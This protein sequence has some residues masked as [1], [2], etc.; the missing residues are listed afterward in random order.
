M[1]REARA[2][3]KGLGPKGKEFKLKRGHNRTR[4]QAAISKSISKK[5][6]QVTKLALKLGKSPVSGSALSIARQVVKKAHKLGLKDMTTG[7]VLTTLGKQL[8]ESL[9]EGAVLRKLYNTRQ[10]AEVE[11][12]F[13]IYTRSEL[14]RPHFY[15]Y[16]QLLKNLKGGIQIC[17]KIVNPDYVDDLL[18]LTF[19]SVV[20]A[21]HAATHL[22]NMNYV[23]TFSVKL[24]LLKHDTGAVIGFAVGETRFSD[25]LKEPYAHLHIVCSA[26]GG[27]KYG[28]KLF[29]AA[30]KYYRDEKVHYG[31]HGRSDGKVR[32]LELDAL[33]GQGDYKQNIK[34]AVM[35]VKWANAMDPPIASRVGLLSNPA[36]RT[37]ISSKIRRGEGEELALSLKHV[38]LNQVSKD[39]YIDTGHYTAAPQTRDEM[40]D[41]GVGGGLRKWSFLPPGYPHGDP[42]SGW[43]SDSSRIKQHG[44][45]LT[46]ENSTDTT[47]RMQAQVCR[48][49]N[50]SD[51]DL[52]FEDDDK[53]I[54]QHVP[55][56]YTK[57][58]KNTKELEKAAEYIDNHGV[59]LIFCLNAPPTKQYGARRKAPVRAKAGATT[60]QKTRTA[61]TRTAPKTR[62]A[63]TAKT[64][65]K[66]KS[67]KP[68]PRKPRKPKA[69]K[70]KA[71]RTRAPKTE[72]QKIKEA[73]RRRAQAAEQRFNTEV[74][75]LFLRAL[76]T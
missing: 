52:M 8:Q 69:P 29:T 48:F 65:T 63:S 66:A 47:K 4:R 20:S 27:R 70:A 43:G 18:H 74:N 60:A 6:E 13:D 46:F 7:K 9:K 36:S 31:A 23:G 44:E 62:T 67:T 33:Q 19:S 35:Y 34:K 3:A 56:K 24:W 45:Y 12:P 51:H 41:D 54:L 15:E 28:Q 68:K 39:R 26:Q 49:V 32:Y 50:C 57:C 59:P 72:A 64:P 11:G 58:E 5:K 40:D 38:A 21:Q 2:L 1:T 76:Y 17:G 71:P 14:D 30:L 10:K 25:T 73:Q 42:V 16:D 37:L 53:N 61:P 75:L 22:K 55:K